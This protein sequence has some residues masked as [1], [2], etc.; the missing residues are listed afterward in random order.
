MRACLT[1]KR[2][3]SGQELSGV[4]EGKTTGAPICLMVANVDHDSSKYEQIKDILRPGHAN[5]TYLEKYGIFDW[6]GGGR[7]SAR[8]TVARVAA[9]AVAEKILS[10]IGVKIV[11]HLKSVGNCFQMKNY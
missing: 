4:F 8:E 11:S 9:G 7:A 6:R 10:S 5:F 3:G 2:N 1:K